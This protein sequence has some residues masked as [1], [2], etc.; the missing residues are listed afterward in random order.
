MFAHV[1]FPIPV[2]RTFVYAVPEEWVG[3]CVPGVEV[4]APF[5]PRTKRGEIGR[6]HV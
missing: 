1:A 3:T 2:R 5:G 6:A 4:T